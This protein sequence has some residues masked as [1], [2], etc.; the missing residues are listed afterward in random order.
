MK[1]VKRCDS[2]GHWILF[3][4]YL[5][6]TLQFC[7]PECLANGPVRPLAQQLSPSLVRVEALNQHAQRCPRCQ[8]PGPVDF[9]RSFW[10]VSFVVLGHWWTRTTLCCRRCGLKSQAW[11]LVFDFLFGWWSW[12]GIVATPAQLVRNLKA[13]CRPPD[14]HQPSA[15]L[16]EKARLDLAQRQLDRERGRS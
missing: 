10:V 12:L 7:T 5:D 15:L 4:T 14:R 1:Q 6:G 16:E 11:A 9:H 13:M 3:D 2:C 8:A